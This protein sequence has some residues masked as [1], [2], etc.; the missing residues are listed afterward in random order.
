MD[1]RD[2]LKIE[3][4]TSIRI[5]CRIPTGQMID[6]LLTA[7]RDTP[8]AKRFLR[9]A[10]DASGN[11]MPRVVNVDKNPAYPAA[12][13]AL[14]AGGAIPIAWFTPVQVSQ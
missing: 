14:K 1:R 8:A 13:E 4:R 9:R 11:P 6:F 10:I 5:E 7:K 12:K 3:A 2:Y